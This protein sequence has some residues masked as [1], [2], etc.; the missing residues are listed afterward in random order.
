MSPTRGEDRFTQFRGVG[1][2]ATSIAQP[3]IPPKWSAEDGT[4]IRWKKELPGSG[5]SQPVLWGNKLFVT[6][7][8]SEKELKPKN[9]ANGVRT[10]QSMG[11][12]FLSKAPDVKIDWTLF[13]LDATSGETIWKKVVYTG[14]PAY[15]VHP[16]NS[17]ATETP[18]VSENAV[19]AYFGAS[20]EIAAFTHDGSPLWN[21]NFGA[22][23]TS[24]SF[25]TGS[26]LAT[27][28]NLVFLQDLSES[29]SDLYA[30]SL[31]TG[32]TAW[33]KSRP[34]KGTSWASPIIWQNQIRNEVVISGGEQIDSYDPQTGNELWT[35]RNVKAATACSLGFDQQRLYFGGSDPFSKGPLFAVNAGGQGDISPDKKNAEFELCAWLSK[36]SA[37]GMSSPA[38]TG[39]AVLIIDKN[40]LQAYRTTDGE[41]I[42]RA[43]VPGLEMINASPILFG[44]N[45]LL[46]DEAGKAAIIDTA[47]EFKVV[48]SGDLADTVWATPAI[49]SQGLYIRGVNALYCISAN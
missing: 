26:S 24:N 32:E 43:R 21:R 2:M 39:S 47:D 40:I 22:H 42:H 31:S 11:M 41:R 46:V 8:V 33:K 28:D 12:G 3:Q 7:A 15:A 1:G 45:L 17:Y 5:W 6:S 37:P 10:P 18:I 49:G 13:C 23:K 36:K 48:S 14:K 27:L 29:T 34:K 20:G 44:S 38:S 16:S 35:L 9:F 30:L 25:G 4:G 19:V